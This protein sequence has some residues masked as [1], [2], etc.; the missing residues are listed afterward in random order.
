MLRTAF[1]PK[2]TA[3]DLPL[4][5][6]WRH[7]VP[8]AGAGLGFGLINPTLPT[9]AKSFSWNNSVSLLALEAKH[10]DTHIL[11]RIHNRVCRLRA[12]SRQRVARTVPSATVVSESDTG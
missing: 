3:S 5:F 6:A 1:I 7:G 12:H 2:R 10:T 4:Q 9:M 11:R 8:M